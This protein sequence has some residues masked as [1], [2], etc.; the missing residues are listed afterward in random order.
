[1]KCKLVVV[2]ALALV[3]SGFAMV[4]N[5][6]VAVTVDGER[7]QFPDQQ[8]V[9]VEGRTLVPVRGVFE[10][11]GFTVR[12]AHDAGIV[13]ARADFE[14][15]IVPGS[16]VATVNGQSFILEVAAMIIDG[17]TMIPLRAIAERVGY[18]VYWNGT[19]G[20][21][22]LVTGRVVPQGLPTIHGTRNIEVM[23]GE[24]II[25]RRGVS[26]YD[27]F[28]RPVDFSVDTSNLNLDIP[29]T[30]RV[31][32]FA[33]DDYGNAA[34]AEISVFVLDVDVNWIYERV[35]AILAQITNENMTQ[36]QQARAVFNWVGTNIS[37]AAAINRDTV[38]EGAFQALRN[39]QGNC[40]I[41]YS[42]SEVML[43]RLGIP[44][45]RVSRVGGTA[46]HVWSIIN[47]D[48]L[49]WHHF[50]ST[51]IRGNPVNRFMFTGSQAVEFTAIIQ[52]T[53]RTPNYYVYDSTLLP[54][55]VW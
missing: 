24:N 29:G 3:L 22:V 26:A 50:D 34:I 51:P 19:L 27:A 10:H 4:V 43:T 54:E 45:M 47:P 23:A 6:Q 11:L 15:I 41:F 35:D 48:G 46:N 53:L 5:A 9:T 13:L 38:Y 31:T 36:V 49:G 39:R 21:V 33:Q 16:D 17:R 30:Y 42:I 52:R 25:L 12:N 37:Y 55:I 28:G 8:P 1:M 14:V 7:V 2:F 40:F 20:T 32:Y 44:N 18:R